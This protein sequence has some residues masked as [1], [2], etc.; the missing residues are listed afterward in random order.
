MA[1][2]GRGVKGLDEIVPRWQKETARA[3]G[4]S[5][6]LFL[7]GAPE[8]IKGLVRPMSVPPDFDQVLLRCA[9]V[10]ETT[11]CILHIQSSC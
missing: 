9:S 8:V 3:A 5:A 4:R 11:T 10:L 1:P 6:L 2:E 7:K